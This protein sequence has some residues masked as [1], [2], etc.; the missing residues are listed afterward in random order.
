MKQDETFFRAKKRYIAVMVASF[1][2]GGYSLLQFIYNIYSFFWM[3]EVVPTMAVK[4][5]GRMARDPMVF[6]SSPQNITN[7]IGG[8]VA[9]IAGLAIWFLIREK[10]LKAVRQETAKKLMLPDERAVIDALKKFDLEL[11]QSKIAIETGLTKVQ[12][13]RAVKRLELKGA[14]EKHGYGV[15]NKIILKKDFL[16]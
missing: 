3:S 1:L 5:V 9:I 15:T 2:Y 13:H 11:T 16:E 6:L 7:P 14:V 8:I 4:G 12:V 10:E